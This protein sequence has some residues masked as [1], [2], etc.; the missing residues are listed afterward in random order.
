MIGLKADIS[1]SAGREEF[2]K[3][4]DFE[5]KGKEGKPKYSDA[6]KKLV[7]DKQ[8]SLEPTFRK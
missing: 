2:K 1:T 8:W 5:G 4:C 3:H 6:F 7:K